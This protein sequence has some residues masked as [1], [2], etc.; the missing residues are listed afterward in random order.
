MMHIR[1]ARVTSGDVARAGELLASLTCW[2]D[3]PK[4]LPK[5]E[6]VSAW[7]DTMMKE[8]AITTQDSAGTVAVYL[9]VLFSLFLLPPPSFQSLT[10]RANASDEGLCIPDAG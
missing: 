9:F 1:G 8:R 10:C 5:K 4:T 7:V 3:N 6:D 2:I